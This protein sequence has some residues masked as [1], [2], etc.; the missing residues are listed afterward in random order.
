MDLPVLDE[1]KLQ[2]LLDLDDGKNA[3]L[4][5]MVGLFSEEA[6]RRLNVILKA[7]ADADTISVR[8]AAHALS[9][10]SGLLGASRIYA[11]ARS[12]E[13]DAKAGTLPTQA[14]VDLLKTSIT[15]VLNALG[16]FLTRTHP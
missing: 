16:N 8:E 7:V 11:E 12:I 10:A 14:K 4:Q 15:E 2:Q 13:Q 9:G 5:E 1:S 3:L 6:P